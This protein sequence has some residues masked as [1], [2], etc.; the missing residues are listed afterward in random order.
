MIEIV[1]TTGVS[2]DLE[3][4]FEI[5]VEMEQPLLDSDHL[6]V[7][8]S[9]QISFPLTRTNQA[10][11]GYVNAM[12][13]EPSVKRLD[14]VI[15]FA[16]REIFSGRLEYDGFED[17]KLRYVFTENGLADLLKS[18]IAP[19]SPETHTLEQMYTEGNKYR[20]PVMIYKKYATTP[21]SISTSFKYRNYGTFLMRNIPWRGAQIP[22]LPAVSIQS[23]LSFL[24]VSRW[25]G[26]SILG[27]LYMLC[28]YGT[29]QFDYEEQESGPAR[30]WGTISKENYP[31]ATG[32]DILKNLCN[33]LCCAVYKSGGRYVLYAGRDF[34]ERWK[35]EE[36]GSILF[37]DEK[38]SSIYSLFVEPRKNYRFAMGDDP[39]DGD[40]STSDADTTE[41]YYR[42]GLLDQNL[43]DHHYRY[44]HLEVNID[45]ANVFK[46][47]SIKSQTYGNTQWPGTNDYCRIVDVDIL[48]RNDGKGENNADAE[49]DFEVKSEFKH[50]H[51]VPDR[52]LFLWNGIASDIYDYRAPL[53]ELP[54]PDDGRGKDLII[55]IMEESDHDRDYFGHTGDSLPS[56][57]ETEHNGTYHS[58]LPV[59]LY[60]DYH[61]SFAEWMGTD[62][63]GVKADLMLTV[64]DLTNLALYKRVNF[65]GRDWMIKKISLTFRTGAS[66]F[67]AVGEFISL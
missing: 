66:Y 45:A 63:T 56:L 64:E 53:I 23:L 9:T 50:V 43:D 14:C 27:K 15:L 34:F 32:A 37:W 55:G 47:Y 38:V 46:V 67:A 19:S 21:G 11:F 1:T 65:R 16:G 29:G 44:R 33:M 10:A 54:T 20:M 24:D 17:D 8:Y 13:L 7:A 59:L 22:F 26:Q 3:K 52:L 12:M 57:V 5:Q 48:Y 60:D 6:P 49:E 42:Y 30:T 61:K 2:L 62:R 41:I 51:T 39:I 36:D 28:P 40:D 18:D 25:D 4:D 58:L 35:A 31:D